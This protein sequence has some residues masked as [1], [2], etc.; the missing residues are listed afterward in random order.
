MASLGRRS[1]VGVTGFTKNY[2]IVYCNYLFGKLEFYNKDHAPMIGFFVSD[3][4]ISGQTLGDNRYVK[5]DDLYSLIHSADERIYRT[6]HYDTQNLESLPIQMGKLLKYT[7]NKETDVV[8]GELV[9]GVQLNIPWPKPDYVKNS[10]K[11]EGLDV[12]LKIS[13]KAMEGMSSEQVVKK[14]GG[15]VD[16]VDMVT[17]DFSGDTDRK[18]GLKEAEYFHYLMEYS[19]LNMKFG[20]SGNLSPENVAE[21]VRYF[22]KSPD[23]FLDFLSINMESGPGNGLS[24]QRMVEYFNNALHALYPSIKK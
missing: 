16:V 21:S 22:K 2:E 3:E 14:L 5:I 20:I 19:N 13:K 24:M 18:V 12:I 7:P 9:D 1:Y 4:S 11:K 15:Y 8:L 6:I 23:K 17:Y 10:I